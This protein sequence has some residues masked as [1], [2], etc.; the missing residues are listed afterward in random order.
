ML[1]LLTIACSIDKMIEYIYIFSRYIR[2]EHTGARTQTCARAR[3]GFCRDHLLINHIIRSA[4]ETMKQRMSTTVM[5]PMPLL[6]PG[7]DLGF[8]G[9]F[10]SASSSPLVYPSES[11]S[12]SMSPVRSSPN[13]MKSSPKLFRGPPE[14]FTWQTLQK[15]FSSWGRIFAC[16]GI[17]RAGSVRRIETTTTA[18]RRTHSP[19]R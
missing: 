10:A 3:P 8:P 1:I 9:N 16:S 4:A 18:M 13:L 11:E 6:S 5:L 17:P 12:S 7:K 15:F 2:Y 14:F 19:L